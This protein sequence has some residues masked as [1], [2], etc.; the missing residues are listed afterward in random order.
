MIAMRWGILC[1]LVPTLGGPVF[2]DALLSVSAT[3]GAQSCSQT[4]ASSASCSV[5]SSMSVAAGQF[6]SPVSAGGSIEFGSTDLATLS[7]GPPAVGPL[8]YSLEGDW[9]MGQGIGL[10]GQAGV[11]LTASLDLPSDSGNWTFYGT[12][13]DATDDQ[14]GGIGPI[15]IFTTDGNGWILGGSPSSFTVSHTPGTPFSVF[16]DVSDV[17][18]AADSSNNLDFQLRM[19]DP[20]STPE[21]A[22]WMLVGGVL[23]L[24][25]TARIIRSTI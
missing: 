6:Y 7:L 2:A 11:T 5:S 3:A 4:A 22:T 20:I 14:G 23:L 25:F 16:I 15:E 9:S 21:P 1:L 24:G 19:V 17:V 13:Y 10:S 18:Q 8:D 12:S